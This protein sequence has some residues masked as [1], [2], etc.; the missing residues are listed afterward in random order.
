[1]RVTRLNPDLTE[2]PEDTPGQRMKKKRLLKKLSVEELAKATGSGRKSIYD[3]ERDIHSARPLFIKQI[4]DALE[5]TPESILGPLP[6]NA[7]LAE[8]IKYFRTCRGLSQIEF[9]RLLGV[10]R[11]TIGLIEQ[12]GFCSQ[13]MN[14]KLNNIGF[15]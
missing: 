13:S 12:G 1:M 4:A 15:S 10:N 6:E 11:D 9:A 7:S 2:L 14:T 8:Q 3:W 5:T